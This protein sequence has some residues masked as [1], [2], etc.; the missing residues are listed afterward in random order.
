MTGLAADESWGRDGLLHASSHLAGSL[1]HA[2][3]EVAGAPTVD[4][5]FADHVVLKTGTLWHEWVAA[6][7]GQQGHAAMLE[8]KMGRWMPTGW[9]GTA[10]WIIWSDEYKAFVLG[11]L[12]TSKGEML[13]WIER[14][15]AKDAHLWQLSAYWYALRD[16]GFPLVKGFGVFYLPKNPVKG[17]VVEPL[18][19]ECEPVEESALYATMEYRAEATRKYMADIG[20]V[21][22]ERPHALHSPEAY[23]S[24]HLAPVQ[25]RKQV[26]RWDTKLGFWEVKLEPNWDTVYC[27]FPDELCN[28]KG[29]GTTKLGEYHLV[30]D[31]VEYRPRKDGNALDIKPTVEPS[32]GD[33]VKRRDKLVTAGTERPAF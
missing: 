8:V 13:R 12:K 14:D 7:L 19:I 25:E 28:C 11:D 21:F 31:G 29:Q 33:I 23:L 9:T 27:R 24:E 15:G 10:D 4:R 18:T 26:L 16:A 5:S 6:K 17:Y 20:L 22:G 1:R 3:L 30:G 32:H 2:Q